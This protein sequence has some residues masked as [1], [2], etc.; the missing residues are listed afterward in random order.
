MSDRYAQELIRHVR[1]RVPLAFAVLLSCLGISTLFEVLRFPERRL[2]MSTVSGSVVALTVLEG[3]LLRW[4][5]NWSVPVLVVFVNV[6]GV[7]INVYHAAVGAPVALCV[8]VLTA[9]LCSSAVLLPWGRRNQALA[10]VGALAAYPMQLGIGGT[11]RSSGAPE[12]RTSWPW[13]RSR[14]SGR[15]CLRASCA[16]TYG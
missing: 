11:I 16:T 4:R 7:T 14:S 12:E 10:C 6:L 2:A 9:L 5:P 3:L 1:G 15:H 8:W 13:S